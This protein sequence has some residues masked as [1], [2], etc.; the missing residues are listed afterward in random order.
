MSK[1][2]EQPDT[3]HRVV[4]VPAAPVEIWLYETGQAVAV[5]RDGARASFADLEDLAVA[6]G[7]SRA[8]TRDLAY[9]DTC[10][11]CSLDSEPHQCGAAESK[12]RW[13]KADGTLSAKVYGIC[14]ECLAKASYQVAK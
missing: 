4:R 11:H 3:Q 13:V 2:P 1:Q 9:K 12:A 10:Y 7:M 6:H 8:A 5:Y 14:R